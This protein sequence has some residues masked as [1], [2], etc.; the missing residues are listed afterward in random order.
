M[1]CRVPHLQRLFEDK[2]G[3]PEEIARRP[4]NCCAIKT[5]L[6]Q[7]RG[8]KLNVRRNTLLLHV[9]RHDLS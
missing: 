3:R 6:S 1:P 2:K 9:P 8:I 4:E 7:R 5:Q